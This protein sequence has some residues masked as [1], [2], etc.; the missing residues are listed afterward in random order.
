MRQRRGE[1]HG[2]LP[3]AAADLQHAP[4][5]REA[6]AQDREYRLAV[7][8]ARRRERLGAHGQKNADT[9]SMRSRRITILLDCWLLATTYLSS[10]DTTTALTVTPLV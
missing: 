5:V 3:R 6:L 8:V 9:P 10:T 4:A 1:V 2:V 7:A